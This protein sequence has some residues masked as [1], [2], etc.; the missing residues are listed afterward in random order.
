MTAAFQRHGLRDVRLGLHPP[1]KWGWDPDRGLW[2]CRPAAWLLSVVPA[3]GGETELCGSVGVVAPPVIRV[4]VRE[5]L[6]SAGSLC[7]A[8]APLVGYGSRCPRVGEKEP[9]S[10]HGPRL[11]CKS[12]IGYALES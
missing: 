4:W 6:C 12:G 9:P 7:G 5:P 8:T 2:P 10:A 11:P 3:A 1:C